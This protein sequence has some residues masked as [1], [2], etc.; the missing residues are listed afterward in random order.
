MADEARRVVEL[1]GWKDE[2]ALRARFEEALAQD[3]R[4]FFYT[5]RRDPTTGDITTSTYAT[6]RNTCRT[7]WLE[8]I[9]G[10]FLQLQSYAFRSFTDGS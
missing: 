3:E 8:L 7:T 1:S 9:G 6:C 10:V 5:L 2:A 4:I